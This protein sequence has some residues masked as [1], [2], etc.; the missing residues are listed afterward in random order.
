MVRQICIAGT[1]LALLHLKLV[2][3]KVQSL[4]CDVHAS[5]KTKTF[6]TQQVNFNIL[7]FYMQIKQPLNNVR[8]LTFPLIRL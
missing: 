5:V 3:Q 1:A 6:T 8:R 4:L 2:A 7:F